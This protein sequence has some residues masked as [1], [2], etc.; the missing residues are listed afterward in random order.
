MADANI[1]DF[2][3]TLVAAS[4]IAAAAPK[5]TNA[6][7]DCA[8]TGNQPLY[9]HAVGTN[10]EIIIPTVDTT[11]VTNIG[12]GGISKTNT[13]HNKAS[14]TLSTKQSTSFTIQSFD[15]LRSALELSELYVGPRMEALLRKADADFLSAVVPGYTTNAIQAGTGGK[16]SRT[17]LSTAKTLLDNQGC[18]TDDAANMF[19]VTSPSVYNTTAADSTFSQNYY[20]GTT[21]AEQALEKGILVPALGA[22]MKKDQQFPTGSGGTNYGLLM[23]RYSFA[24]RFAVEPKLLD[25]NFLR[26]TVV[27]PKP[28]VPVKIQMWNDPN[29]QGLTIHLS[30]VYAYT[31]ARPEYG[32]L[33]SC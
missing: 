11:T 25:D 15:Q 26:E 6:M 30:T 10:L 12:N 22:T 23:H 1:S 9:N 32:V 20:V 4:N 13:A 24:A 8:Y 16:F 7:L 27:F 5:F 18:P 31:V 33:M 19:I 3:E 21:A 28:N 29:S 14:L 17:Q 2:F